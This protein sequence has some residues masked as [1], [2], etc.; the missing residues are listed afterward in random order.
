MI[1]KR[2]LVHK[3][4][5]EKLAALFVAV[6]KAGWRWRK[7]SSHIVCYP[8]DG[9]RPLILS[10]TAYDGIA[11]RSTEAQFRRSGLKI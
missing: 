7:G 10:L 8:P 4:R 6:D 5:S 1:D 2:N 11:T 3:F 9:S